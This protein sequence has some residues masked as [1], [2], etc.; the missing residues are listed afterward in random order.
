MMMALNCRTWSCRQS[1]EEY[2]QR[3][4]ESRA[5]WQQRLLR[6][7]TFHATRARCNAAVI[8]AE[9]DDF[10]RRLHPGTHTSVNVP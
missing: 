3:Q 2:K 1:W 5:D 8:D 6:T 7:F 4:D 10:H 9:L